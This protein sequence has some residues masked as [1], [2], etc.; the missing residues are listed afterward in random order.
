[1]SERPV[2][3]PV[4]SFQQAVK[5]LEKAGFEVQSRRGHGHVILT[6]PGWPAILSIPRHKTLKAGTLRREIRKAGLT[7]RQFLDLL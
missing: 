7:V 1:M 6:R 4:I 5:A 3:L 2:K